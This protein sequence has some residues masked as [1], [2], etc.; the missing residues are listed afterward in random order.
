VRLATDPAFAGITGGF[1]AAEGAKPLECPV[2]GRDEGVQRALWDVTAKLLV[3]GVG[4]AQG[5]R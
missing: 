2:T 4:P 5:D 1:Y 3:S